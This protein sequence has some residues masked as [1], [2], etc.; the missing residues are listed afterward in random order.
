MV[1]AVNAINRTFTTGGTYTV[2]VRDDATINTGGYAIVWQSLVNP[3]SAAVLGCGQDARGTIDG[4]VSTPPW[5]I[6]SFTAS[7]NDVVTIRARNTSG[8]YFTPDLELYGPA[9]ALVGAVSNA[10]WLFETLA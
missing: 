3:C 8:G 4:A 7:A 6:Y 9:G 10:C 1:S 2:F 5:G